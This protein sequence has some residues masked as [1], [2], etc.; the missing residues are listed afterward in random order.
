VLYNVH[1]CYA[2]NARA[3]ARVRKA[4]IDAAAEDERK[5]EEVEKVARRKSALARPAG[6]KNKG[7]KR[8]VSTRVGLRSR[9]S[10]RI[11]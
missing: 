4:A 1:L 8:K 2:C 5:A 7:E 11:P 3:V 6:D 9:P 10:G